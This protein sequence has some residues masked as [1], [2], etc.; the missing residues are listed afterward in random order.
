MRRAHATEA[1]LKALVEDRTA[2]LRLAKEVAEKA[3]RAK[4]TIRSTECSSSG[5]SSA[6]GQMPEMDGY[7]ATVRIRQQQKSDSGTTP[8]IALTANA[9]EG[10]RERCL[11]AEMDAFV[12]KPIRTTELIRLVEG[13]RSA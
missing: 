12:S 11:R 9:I 10:D 6:A 5:Y 2:D 3:S 4:R 13:A 7:E 1:S 8:I